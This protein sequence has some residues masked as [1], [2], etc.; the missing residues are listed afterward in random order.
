[1]NRTQLTF[2]LIVGL[3]V[4][5]I[6]FFNSNRSTTPT[7][8]NTPETIQTPANAVVVTVS[9]SNTKQ[10]WMDQAVAKFNGENPK[11][12]S[13][14][15]VRVEVKHV[16]SGSSLEDIQNGIA[17]PT[18]W[19][20]G[21]ASWVEQLN[22]FWQQRNNKPIASQDCTAT[23]YAPVGFVMW[24]PNGRGAGLAR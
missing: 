11:L 19:S 24:R 3:A 9:S 13:G 21:D 22:G 4:G 18:V 12:A 8:P 17:Q 15:A 16:T 2:L 6:Y 10:S 23:I 5:F 20:P 1:M 14:K 7:N